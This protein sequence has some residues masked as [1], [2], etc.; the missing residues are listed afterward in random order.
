MFAPK[1]RAGHLWSDQW[2]QMCYLPPLLCAS[3][4]PSGIYNKVVTWWG[5]SQLTESTK[6][7]SQLS[8]HQRGAVCSVWPVANTD[9]SRGCRHILQRGNYNLDKYYE[10][11]HIAEANYRVVNRLKISLSHRYNRKWAIIMSVNWVNVSFVRTTQDVWHVC[12]GFS[13]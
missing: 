3:P 7:L 12:A 8:A 13:T 11:K 2:W 10:F 1:Y 9:K 6:V 5:L 4:L